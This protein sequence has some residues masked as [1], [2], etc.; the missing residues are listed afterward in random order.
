[1]LTFEELDAELAHYT[2]RPGWMLTLWQDRY[3]GTYL[4]IVAEVENSYNPGTQVQLRIKTWVPIMD[5]K[6][7]FCEW[8]FWRLRLIEVHE[9]MEWFKRRDVPVFDPHEDS[10]PPMEEVK[11]VWARKHGTMQPM[12]E[13]TP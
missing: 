2:Y 9:C 11:S 6:K 13:Q 8:L 1:M 4:Y 10:E 5:T 12:Q 3:E 7:Q